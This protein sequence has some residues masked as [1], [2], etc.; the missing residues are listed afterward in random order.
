LLENFSLKYQ[1]KEDTKKS[2][3][4]FERQVS[5]FLKDIQIKHMVESQQ[6]ISPRREE[7]ETAMLARKPIGGWSC[8]SCEK[9][10][11]NINGRTDYQ[12]WNRLPQR[13]PNN[14][15]ARVGQGFSKILAMMKPAETFYSQ[16][17]FNNVQGSKH[18]KG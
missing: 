7:E 15:I 16:S 10:I 6:Q 3:K 18:A 5:H 12:A 4:H 9:D 17:Q 14:R 1:D 11:T 8:A 2:F 13:S